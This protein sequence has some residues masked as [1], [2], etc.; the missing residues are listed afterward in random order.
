MYLYHRA[1]EIDQE[2]NLL[3]ETQIKYDIDYLTDCTDY[4]LPPY[5]LLDKL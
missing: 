3:A 2:S 1:M 5:V 4:V